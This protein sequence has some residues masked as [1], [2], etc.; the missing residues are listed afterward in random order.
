MDPGLAYGAVV[1]AKKKEAAASRAAIQQDNA[2]LYRQAIDALTEERQ[3][4]GLREQIIREKDDIIQAQ[5]A[6]IVSL[7]ERLGLS[8]RLLNEMNGIPMPAT[9]SVGD[10]R[11]AEMYNETRK[12]TSSNLEHG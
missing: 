8:V 10:S 7:R 9:T 1:L 11:L 12:P 4:A 2:W 6:E 5:Y 3:S